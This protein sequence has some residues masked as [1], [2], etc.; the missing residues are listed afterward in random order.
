MVGSG[1]AVWLFLS[2]ASV[3][4]GEPQ[5]Q[6]VG[7]A[8]WSL[9]SG[10]AIASLSEAGTATVPQRRDVA[11]KSIVQAT[12]ELAASNPWNADAQYAAAATAFEAGNRAAARDFLHQALE[13][14]PA[15]RGALFDLARIEFDEGKYAAASA[16]YARLRQL[17]PSHRL[18]AYRHF[19]CSL[20]LGE[21][22]EIDPAALP[23][24]STPGLYA[25]AAA[26]WKGGDHQSAITLARTAR[27][28][29]SPNT[30]LFEADLRLVGFYE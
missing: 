28:A 23:A 7:P 15:H 27:A 2:S 11:G 18:T 19:L 25:R 1:A 30:P 4:D 16:L 12:R 24:D 17:N 14:E 21:Q 5:H 10:P 3:P 26:A 13:L 9:S 8:T 6:A 29:G 22:Q 20:M